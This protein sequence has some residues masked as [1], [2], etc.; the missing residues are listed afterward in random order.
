[1]AAQNNSN[2]S[3]GQQLK[4]LWLLIR[5][6]VLV[7]FA[8]L[9]FGLGL[10]F[11]QIDF[12]KVAI[13]PGNLV[14]FLFGLLLLWTMIVIYQLTLKFI[15]LGQ[16]LDD[17]RQQISLLEKSASPPLLLKD[18][19]L[20][21]LAAHVEF[22]KDAARQLN[23]VKLD[24]LRLDCRLVGTGPRKDAEVTYY[25][26]G[27]NISNSPLNGLYLSIAADNLVPLDKLGAKLYNLYADPGRRIPRPPQLQGSD[28]MRKD[29][30]LPFVH[31]GIKP[32]DSF[33]LEL[34][35]C[36]P[37]IFVPTKDYWFLDNLDYE[38][39][40]DKLIIALEFVDATAR[41]VESH[42]LN[43]VSKEFNHLGVLSPDSTNPNKFVFEK[44]E[45][46]KDTYYIIVFEAS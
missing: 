11:I 18:I 3:R 34:T 17:A 22:R 4:T 32:L 39:I 8:I 36:W 9:A 23:P 20:S 45:A 16:K 14:Y 43:S 37:E 13:P 31:P 46:E 24:V 7:L 30:F 10:G 42:S 38:G 25:F 27:K 5:K 29:L 6:S 26:K 41:Y 2:G 33:E 40:T 15:E 19:V 21:S 28:G 44:T 35:Y 1:M 12:I